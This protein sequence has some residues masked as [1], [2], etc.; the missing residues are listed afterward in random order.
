MKYVVLLVCMTLSQLGPTGS[1]G[2]CF[3]LR[4]YNQIGLVGG[5][6]FKV[7]SQPYYGKLTIKTLETGHKFEAS[8]K[9]L[10]FVCVAECL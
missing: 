3:T 4:Q 7:V 10:G 6:L 5:P 2:S 9:L 1:I 8:V